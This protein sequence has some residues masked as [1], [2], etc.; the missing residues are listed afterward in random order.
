MS[1]KSGC[2]GM[3]LKLFGIGG[4]P[5]GN[6]P[7][8][9][10]LR[11]E[12]LSAAE[13]S[14][15]HVLRQVVGERVTVCAKVRLADVFFVERPNENAAARNRIAAKHVDFLLCDQATMRPLAGIELDDASHARA[16]RQE[17]DAFVEQVFAAAGLPL[18]RFPAQR[19]YTLAEV[20]GK[21][22]VVFGD[23]AQGGRPPTGFPTPPEGDHAQ[24]DNGPPGNAG[25]EP[26][27]PIA[28]QCPKCGI[29]LVLR[30]GPHGNFYGCSHF[31]KCRETAPVG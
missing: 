30:T 21:V 9:Y 20:E 23:G 6:G 13:V 26:P 29:P 25:Q 27:A 4:Q 3:L 7:L 28:S 5:M 12:F 10:R 15:Y 18:V 16:D 17:R 22:S 31:P 24:E 1:E 11:D 8:S 2:L 14:F 19:A